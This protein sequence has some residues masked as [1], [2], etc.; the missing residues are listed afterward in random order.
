MQLDLDDEETRALLSLLLERAVGV[1][2]K[3]KAPRLDRRRPLDG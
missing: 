3:P 1:V 2:E